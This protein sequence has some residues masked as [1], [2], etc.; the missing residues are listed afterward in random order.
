MNGESQSSG[1]VSLFILNF[2]GVVCPDLS[3]VS[4][5]TGYI[6]KK[7]SS[8]DVCPRGKEICRAG[9]DQT[10]GFLLLSLVL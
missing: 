3:T 7:R 10:S 5:H 1:Q 9:D 6:S 2:V 8:S 4:Q